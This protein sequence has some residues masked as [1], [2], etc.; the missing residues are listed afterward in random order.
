MKIILLGD[1]A[2]RADDVVAAFIVDTDEAEENE[3]GIQVDLRHGRSH[4]E[5]IH[6][7]KTQ[8]A[9]RAALQTFVIDWNN[10]LKT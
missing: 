6:D 9:A 4:R 2:L 5:Y 3:T 10:A 8:A 7:F 1:L